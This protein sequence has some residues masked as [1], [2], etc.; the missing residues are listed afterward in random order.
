M[1]QL[2]ALGSALVVS[3]TLA[4]PVHGVGQVEGSDPLAVALAAAVD[5]LAPRAATSTEYSE[6]MVTLRVPGKTPLPT[7]SRAEAGLRTSEAV[8]AAGDIASGRV[9]V[10]TAEHYEDLILC[11]PEG[12]RFECT[13]PPGRIIAAPR[14]SEEREPGH[15]EWMIS[16]IEAAPAPWRLTAA[17]LSVE[18]VREGSTWRVSSVTVEE[19]T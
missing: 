15:Q 9:W 2:E 17:T 1:N 4:I 18:L 8:S 7:L 3:T 5:H 6:V 14:V 11:K 19:I 13:L 10:Y 16:V 12:R